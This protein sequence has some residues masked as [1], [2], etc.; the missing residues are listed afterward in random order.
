M[1]VNNINR[2]QMR[3]REEYKKANFE[4]VQ[5][6]KDEKTAAKPQKGKERVRVRLIPIWLRLV[7]LVVFVFVSLAA[8]A[9]VG[10]GVLGNG[11][12]AD[13]FKESTWTHIRDLIDK[14]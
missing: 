9:V 2:E 6:T 4:A 7:L 3:T 5:K 11:K 12:A 10:Y 14:K 8:G 13:V 1:S